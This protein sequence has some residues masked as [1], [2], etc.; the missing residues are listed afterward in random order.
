LHGHG[1][2]VGLPSLGTIFGPL[3]R[4]V[5]QDLLAGYRHLW[6]VNHPR[7]RLELCWLR[8]GAVWGMDF[9]ELSQPIDGRCSYAFT[10]RDL[11]SGLQLLWQPV[12]N[13]TALCAI[14]ELEL[15]FRIHGAPL[16]LKSDNGSAFRARLLK[17]LLG[18]WQV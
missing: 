7:Q 12:A 14:G 9:T 17:A 18:R 4:V 15:L 13:E 6:L 5:L 3:P 16:V 2:Q 8:P 11:A 10:V 1:P